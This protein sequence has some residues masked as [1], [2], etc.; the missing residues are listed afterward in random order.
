M[1]TPFNEYWLEMGAAVPVDV[2][3]IATLIEEILRLRDII[4]SL[5]HDTALQNVGTAQQVPTKS[6]ANIAH[7]NRQWV[8][9]TNEEVMDRWP[10]ETRIEFARWVEAKLKEKNH[11]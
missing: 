2:E 5:K 3:T 4:V 8:G 6:D 10:C 7:I 1:S 9:L 11:G